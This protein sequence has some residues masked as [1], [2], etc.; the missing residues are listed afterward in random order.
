ME[1]PAAGMPGEGFLELKRE[2]GLALAG[3]FMMNLM[4][5]SMKDW[6]KNSTKNSTRNS[7]MKPAKIFSMFAS[8]SPAV[9]RAACIPG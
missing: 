4:T 6:I 3:R 9:R 5:G 1:S 2:R 8:P 7:T